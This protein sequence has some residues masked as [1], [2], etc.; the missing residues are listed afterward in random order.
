MEL[1]GFVKS[2]KNALTQSKKGQKYKLVDPFLR[3]YY[4][5][6]L[7]H[8]NIISKNLMDDI[9]FNLVKPKINLWMG[10]AFENFCMLNISKIASLL[11]IKNLVTYAGPVF[12]KLNGFQFDLI[13]V[14]R[15]KTISICEIKYYN[16]PVSTNIVKDFAKKLEKFNTPK[17]YSIEKLLI[18]SNEV[19][20]SLNDLGYFDHI[21]TGNDFFKP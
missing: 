5:Q 14:R 15:D 7:P 3:F 12:S 11:Q 4:S 1:S 10:F 21:L 13:F 6:I 9:Y 20:K 18:A 16:S 2:Y 8:N 17:G 19:D